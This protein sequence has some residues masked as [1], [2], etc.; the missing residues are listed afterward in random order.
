[1]TEVNLG[2]PDWVKQKVLPVL[3]SAGIQAAIKLCESL[4]PLGK[5]YCGPGIN[6]LLG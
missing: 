5:I 1:M 2:L 3:K 4:L 6:A